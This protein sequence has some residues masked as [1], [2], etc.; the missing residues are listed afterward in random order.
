MPDPTEFDLSAF[1]LGKPHTIEDDF[2]PLPHL[3]S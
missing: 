1:D 3:L 2:T